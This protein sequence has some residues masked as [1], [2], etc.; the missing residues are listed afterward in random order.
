MLLRDRLLARMTDM[1]G[2][3]DYVVLAAEVL[4]IRNA[5]PVLAKRL[6]EQALVVED[7]REVW[8]AT[9]ERLCADAP[10][11]PGVYVLRDSGGRTLYVGKANNIRRRLQAHFAAR[12][13]RYLKPEFARAASVA[14]QQVGSEIE[15]LLLEAEWI[16]T[17]TP[18]ANV[19]VSAPALD[20]RA[21]P[22]VLLRDTLLVLPSATDDAVE[23]LAARVDGTLLLQR[24]ARDGGGLA[25]RATALRRFFA[26]DVLAAP[27]KD[28]RINGRILHALAP[29]VFSWLAG[30]GASAT[31][32]DPH[33][34]PSAREL[35]RR[36]QLL[37]DDEQL[38]SERLVVMRSTPPDRATRR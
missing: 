25:A 1:G 27:T 35:Q 21:I 3:L 18:L 34:V 30:R 10:S 19:Q 2:S 38:F 24:A 7:R 36:L 14:W 31:R 6:V 9:G 17:L 13:W 20:R 28:S 37:F 12:R 29:L 15:A 5:P 11:V 4:G 26:G 16:A 8:L 23:L 32:L 33:D 22:A